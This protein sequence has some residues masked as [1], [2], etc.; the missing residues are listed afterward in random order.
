MKYIIQGDVS[1][2]VGTKR[3]ANP[4]TIQEMMGKWQAHNPI[5]MYFSLSRRRFTII[6][7]AENEDA[8][9][10]ALHSTWD[11]FEDYP[12]VWPVADQNEFPKILQ[13]ISP[14]S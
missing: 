12:E 1:T 4:A 2:E 13:R 9:F 7:E 5:G 10:E 11:F 8:F 6:L 14:S 3:E